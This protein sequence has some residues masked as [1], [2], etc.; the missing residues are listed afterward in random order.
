MPDADP[1]LFSCL[2]ERF[3]IAPEGPLPVCAAGWVAEYFKARLKRVP[4]ALGDVLVIVPTRSAARTLRA[5]LLDE[6]QRR[7]ISGVV[8]LRV[9]TFEQ[10]L[11]DGVRD[12]SVISPEAAFCLWTEVLEDARAEDFPALF[13][14]GKPDRAQFGAF[15]AQIEA[16]CGALAENLLTIQGAAARL[17]GDEDAGKWRDLAALDEE[18]FRR[19]RAMGKLSREQALITAVCQWPAV[20]WKEVVVLGHPGLSRAQVALLCR[21]GGEGR[22]RLSVGVFARP[23]AAEFF[24]EWGR[25][26]DD[27]CTKDIGIAD[28]DICRSFD[29]AAQARTAAELVAAYGADGPRAVAIACDQNGSVDLFKTHLRR[30]AEVEG[31]SLEG[32]PLARTAVCEWLKALAQMGHER[33]FAGVRDLLGSPYMAVY[34]K[35]R[36]GA[37]AR[38]L[39]R[40][41]DEIQAAA[42]PL[43]LDA[44]IALA[45]K[46]DVCRPIL[47][48]LGLW[49][50]EIFAGAADRLREAIVP[51]FDAFFADE[52]HGDAAELL[53]RDAVLESLERMG[54][55]ERSLKSQPETAQVLEFLAASLAKRF[56]PEAHA[57][58]EL[59]LRDWMEIYWSAHPHVV[60]AD[61]NEGVVPSTGGIDPYLTDARRRRLGLYCQKERHARD[62]AMLEGL[63]RSRSGE[64]YACSLL[65]AGQDADADPRKPSRLLLQC[66]RE[67]L[68]ARVLRLFSEAEPVR[69]RAEFATLWRLRA[70]APVLGHRLS[71]TALR[72]YLSSPWQFYLTHLLKARPFDPGQEELDAMGLGTLFHGVWEAFA[73]GHLRDSQDAE[74]IGAFLAGTLEDIAARLYGARPDMFVRLQ[75]KGIEQRLRACAEAQARWR[76]EGWKIV[77]A[78]SAHQLAVGDWILSAKFDRVD[79][80]EKTGQWMVID[81]KTYDSAPAGCARK[82]HLLTN[83]DGS[84]KRWKDLQLPLYARMACGAFSVSPERMGAAYFLAP[85]NI[86]DTRVE[87]WDDMD[88]YAEAAWDEA[89]AALRRI[90]EMKFSPREDA[91]FDNFEEVFGFSE[92]ALLRLGL[93]EGVAP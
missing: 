71:V 66:G 82:N 69:D 47:E 52:A 61:M 56:V 10:L 44:A 60:L 5:C 23:D 72:D 32:R 22:T 34:V 35:A 18:F 15:V 11:A 12:F 53:A 65:L 1:L 13:L 92:E 75:L 37:E 85:K 36:F 27:Y 24:D 90:G 58:A 70:S 87:P 16:L 41:L 38:D 30:C 84:V 49:L 73:K 33:T 7:G 57:Q 8:G 81:Y 6:F 68:P 93:V 17:D 29:I 20:A 39:R 78:E 86:S 83:R 19:C 26:L 25:P 31:A 74:R 91:A 63:Y 14:R 51:V 76:G 64:G 43:D 28:A 80:N 48:W 45:Q 21:M 3:F 54:E 42:F 46:G 89:R 62:A 88:A 67:G 9:A 79:C 77:S 59:P 40:A 50:D 2:P 55:A 4:P